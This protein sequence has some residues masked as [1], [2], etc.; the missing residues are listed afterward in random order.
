MDEA[1]RIEPL[2]H[3]GGSWV[4][5]GE[6]EYRVPPLAFRSLQELAPQVET[7]KTMGAMPQAEHMDAIE[8][9]VH[10][11][12]VR[13]YPSLTVADVSSMLDIGNFQDVLAACLSIAGFR[14]A[15]ARS[16]GE[17]AASTGAA[18]TAP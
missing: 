6:E 14:R 8:K 4:R 1:K 12:I 10:A 2:T 15:E 13:N 7:L 9:I 16:P 18:S 5:F 17:M 11:A 3:R